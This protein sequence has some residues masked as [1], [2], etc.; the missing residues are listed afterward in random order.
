MVYTVLKMVDGD[1]LQIAEEMVVVQSR[2][3]R[4]RTVAFKTTTGSEVLVNPMHVVSAHEADEINSP[5]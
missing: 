3:G 2:L 5:S 4:G 1:K